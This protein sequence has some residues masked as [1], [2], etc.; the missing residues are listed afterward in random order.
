[1][2]AQILASDNPTNDIAESR[3]ARNG[4]SNQRYCGSFPDRFIRIASAWLTQ[5]TFIRILAVCCLAIASP[6]SAQQESPLHRGGSLAGLNLPGIGDQSTDTR[7]YIVQLRTPSAAEYHASLVR[8]ANRS[9]PGTTR[10]ASRTFDRNS[11]GIRSYTQ[12]LADE[13][14]AVLS[15]VAVGARKIYSYR[16]SMN[17][18]AIHMTE[19][20]AVKMQHTAEVMQVWEDEIRPLV[21]N[22]SAKF[23]GLF[24]SGVGLR[25]APGLDGDGIVIGVIDSGIS[26]QHP[27]LKDTR[28][29]DRP[30]LCRSAWAES[31]LLGQWLCRRYT[32]REDQLLFEPPEDW[33]GICQIGPE[34][35]EDDCNNK[36][37]GARYFFDGAV[38]SGPIDNDEIFSAR[39]VDGHGTHT[40]TTA[41]GNKVQA[42]IFG[43]LLGR[44]EGMAPKARIAAYKACWLRPGETRS[45]C[46]TSDLAQAI[47]MA[48]ADGVDII[49][50]SVGNTR[51]DLIAPDDIALMAAAKA[52]VFTVVAA[53]NEGPGLATIGS[54]AGSPWVIT[55]GASSR[56][57]DHSVEAM[58]VLS[59][60][61]VAGKYAVKEAS[62]TPALMDHDPLEGQLVLVDDN[63]DTLADGS[64]GTTFDGCENLEND[65]EVSGNIAFIQ[66]GGCAFD[67]KIRN[68]EDAGAIGVVVFNIAGDP[69]VMTGPFG[70]VNI[71]A[72]MVGQADGTLLLDEINAGQTVNAV[73]DKG[74]FLTV[75]DTGNVMGAFSSRGPAPVQDILKPDVTAPGINILAGFSA[76]AVNSVSGENF[77]FLTGTSMSTPHVAG[78]AALLKQA[79]PDWFPAE[80]RSALMTTAHQG[81]N[82]QDGETAANPFDFGAG[83]IDPNK[84]VDPGLVYQVTDDE[85][86]AYACGIESPAVDPTR[87]DALAA[88]GL[89]FEPADMNQPAITLSRLTNTRTIR[90]RVTN[91]SDEQESY[92]AELS[93]PSGISVSVSP[94]ALTIGPGESATFEV[95][96]NYASGPLDLWRFGSLTWVSND[97]SVRS[98]LSV[99]P[100]SISAPTEVNSFGG[101]G[102]LTFPVEFGYSGAY[103][104]RVHGLKLPLVLSAFV[105]SDPTKTFTPRNGNGVTSHVYDVPADQAYLRFALFDELTDGDDDL[106]MF[107]YYCPDDIN[108]DKIGESGGATSSEQ[109]NVLFPGAGTYVVFVHGFETDNVN[110]GPGTNYDIVAWQ[111]GLNDDEGN[112]TA[113]GP[114]LVN[115][116]TIADVTVNWSGLLPNTIY[117]GGISHNTPQGLS[118]ITVIGI[119]N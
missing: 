59:P 18:F 102:S 65:A 62:F 7:V 52:G 70:A 21:T 86:D 39:D 8:Q 88:S 71:P 68:A 72:L 74:F 92:Q 73:L 40:A 109:F 16:Y 117:L 46:N 66:R 49:S 6:V 80:F 44:V 35:T 51:R 28:E 1:M 76:D 94:A 93:L 41:A 96:F 90:R 13:Q 45:S 56:E 34:F 63:T 54:P 87:C 48:V 20:Q 15:R 101:S 98:V 42:S 22:H 104:P 50:Y 31:S 75:D 36:L 91:V 106:D 81:V 47:D 32:K 55:T 53:G 27:A 114:A 84:A 77:A 64:S 69:I 105:A 17:G 115:A 83:H 82:Q 23:L 4:G 14:D 119:Q 108:C 85:Y 19:G 30:R 113:S 78:V 2:L 67:I 25:G 89:S 110:G 100:T 12:R 111:F 95:T 9:G 26:P 79:H 58:Q 112:M 10:R 3:L 33:N 107:V 43:T 38:A 11:A 37:I 97:H 118:S 5:V 103:T 57:G 99:R 61:S 116:G 29:A 60:P 24:D